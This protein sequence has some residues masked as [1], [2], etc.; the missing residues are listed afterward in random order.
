MFFW[1]RQLLGQNSTGQPRT[2]VAPLLLALLLVVHSFDACES[3]LG[4]PSSQTTRS[5]S[6]QSST[7]M[8][9]NHVPCTVC[10]QPIDSHQDA[11]DSTSEVAVPTPSSQYQVEY[12]AITLSAT[13]AVLPATPQ[14]IAL[15]GS[16]H[17]S[18]EPPPASFLSSSLRS[19]LPNRAPPLSA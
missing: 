2:V 16:L 19:S 10:R 4:I 13:V 1:I 7:C 14:L 5:L 9:K 12:Q 17:G 8:E 6:L 11:C 18:A 15:S 3:H